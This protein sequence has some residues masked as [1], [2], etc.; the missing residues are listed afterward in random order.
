ML[1]NNQQIHY[2]ASNPSFGINHNNQTNLSVLVPRFAT[3]QSNTRLSYHWLILPLGISPQNLPHTRVKQPLDFVPMIRHT[4]IK[5]SIS[6]YLAHPLSRYL[7]WILAR[8]NNQTIC[9]AT[10]KE[11]IV[12]HSALPP[13]PP[14]QLPHCWRLSRY[15]LCKH[16]VQHLMPQQ[17]LPI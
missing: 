6:L 10:I 14:L 1:R 17:Q 11:P 2:L 5:K 3:R 16:H 9:H 15:P 8:G 12:L 4:T 13:P 7:S